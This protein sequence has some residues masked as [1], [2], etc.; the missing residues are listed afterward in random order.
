MEEIASTFS[1]AGQPDGFHLA[2]SQKYRRLA[3]L[4]QPGPAV[5]LD[6]VLNAL[7]NETGK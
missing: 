2:T 5:S 7:Q 4:K 3:R 6:A 1:D